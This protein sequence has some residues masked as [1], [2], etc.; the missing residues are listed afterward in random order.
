[1]NVI[2][3]S[4]EAPRYPKIGCENAVKSTCCDHAGSF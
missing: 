1:V 2:V 4:P 3:H